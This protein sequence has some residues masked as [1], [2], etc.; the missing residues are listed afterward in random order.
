MTIY[1]TVYICSFVVLIGG[2]RVGGLAK[3]AN[4]W[5]N[6]AVSFDSQSFQNHFQSR[7]KYLYKLAII[8]ETGRDDVNESNNVSF[9]S[10]N[11]L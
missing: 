9:N 3:K 11:C 8:E 4:L 7:I 10:L 1:L 2:Y 6:F 5:N